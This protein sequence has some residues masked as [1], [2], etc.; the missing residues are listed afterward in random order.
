MSEEVPGQTTRLG[1][2]PVGDPARSIGEAPE[3]VDGDNTVGAHPVQPQAVALAGRHGP[4]LDNYVGVVVVGPRGAQEVIAGSQHRG[5]GDVA[6][7]AGTGHRVREDRPACLAVQLGQGDASDGRGVHRAGHDEAPLG[8]VTAGH[9][10]V[11]AARLDGHPV[12][13]Q[14]KKPDGWRAS[15]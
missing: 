15:L 14:G 5:V 2:H 10:L 11:E 12:G 6:A 7:A 8:T 3:V 1:A 13:R 4:Q 9:Q